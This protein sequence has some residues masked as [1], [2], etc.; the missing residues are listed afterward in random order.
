MATVRQQMISDLQQAIWK[1]EESKE[2]IMKA[3]PSRT[4]EEIDAMFCG[5]IDRI[6]AI[7]EMSINAVYES[8]D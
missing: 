4:E 7:A 8:E 6:V 2:L 1:L 3:F 5:S